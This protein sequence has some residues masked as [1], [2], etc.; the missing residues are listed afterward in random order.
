VK[1][2]ILHL[3]DYKNTKKRQEEGEKWISVTREPSAVR[4]KKKNQG[5]GAY[6]K[7]GGSEK[8]GLEV[9]LSFHLGGRSEIV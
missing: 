3:I 5:P 1:P 8:K 7:K 9:L 6:S 2:G 4:G